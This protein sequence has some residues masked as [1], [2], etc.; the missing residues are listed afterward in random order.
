MKQYKIEKKK[1][2]AFMAGNNYR[3]A[4]TTDMWTADN[5]KKGYMAI[6]VHFIDQS[7][8]VVLLTCTKILCS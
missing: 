2:I 1:A 6:T 7:W 3:V 8:L 5:Q 4:I